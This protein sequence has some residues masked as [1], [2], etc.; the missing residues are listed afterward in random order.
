MRTKLKGNEN[1]KYNQEPE[2][3]LICAVYQQI[4][5]NREIIY[6]T[7]RRMIDSAEGRG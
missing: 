4:L 7:S 5:V 6:G 3:P 1:R 2:S